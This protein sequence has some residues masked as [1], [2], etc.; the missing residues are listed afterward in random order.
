MMRE[1]HRA[2]V[3]KTP[4]AGENS[5]VRVV[6]PKSPRVLKGVLL[7]KVRRRFGGDVCHYVRLRVTLLRAPQMFARV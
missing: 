6:E 3:K 4:R 2:G 7:N 5:P 1:V